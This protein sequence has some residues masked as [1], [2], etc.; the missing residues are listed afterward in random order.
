M[1]R[2]AARR[3]TWAFGLTPQPRVGRA[4]R[5]SGRLGLSSLL[6]TKIYTAPTWQDSFQWSAPPIIQILNGFLVVFLYA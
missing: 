5:R 2:R 1:A 4:R 3:P 6:Q